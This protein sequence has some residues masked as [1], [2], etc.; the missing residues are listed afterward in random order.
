MTSAGVLPWEGTVHR[1]SLRN[2]GYYDLRIERCEV[3]RTR[4]SDDDSEPSS[5]PVKDWS[6]EVVPG[7][8]RDDDDKWVSDSDGR[9]HSPIVPFVGYLYADNGGVWGQIQAMA[10]FGTPE[11]SFAEPNEFEAQVGDALAMVI[12]PLY[13]LCRRTLAQQS[14]PLDTLLSL[15]LEG[16]LPE[17]TLHWGGTDTTG[18]G[19]PQAD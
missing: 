12:E 11:L 4:A 10:I 5:E 6:I 14:A 1:S 3:G 16:P 7:V 15:P 2:A 18:Q 9:F 17:V 19:E 8:E 13:D